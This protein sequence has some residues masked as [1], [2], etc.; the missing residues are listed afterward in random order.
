MTKIN[1][2]SKGYFTI[3]NNQLIR[4]DRLSWKAR[5]IFTYLWSMSDGW[6]FK[7]S[8]VAKHASD[9][10]DSLN[11]GLK[12]LEE[13]GYLSRQQKRDDNGKLD[14]FEWVLTDSPVIGKP[15]K[16]NPKNADFPITENPSPEKPTTGNPPLSNNN[17]R[18][19]NLSSNKGKESSVR[20]PQSPQRGLVEEVIDYLNL[21]TGKNFRATTP[22][23]IRDISSRA[24]EGATL[25]DFKKVIDTKCLAWKDDQRMNE[26]LRPITLFSTKFESYLNE[27]P[28]QQQAPRRAKGYQF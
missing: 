2:Q 17:L 22:R 9:G 27:Q 20:P 14:G 18:S 16:N 10:K 1:K 23:T 4:D 25:S 13:Y 7:A 6:D 26:Y 8:E 15:A 3:T 28:K 21:K 5:G 24:K 11:S 12:E 19:I